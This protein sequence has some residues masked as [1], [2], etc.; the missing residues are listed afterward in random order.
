M[1]GTLGMGVLMVGPIGG[2]LSGAAML[3]ASAA[4]LSGRAMRCQGAICSATFW[5]SSITAMA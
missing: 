1:A 2:A 4:P 5:P 3:L